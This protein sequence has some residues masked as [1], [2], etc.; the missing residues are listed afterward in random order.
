MH[1]HTTCTPPDEPYPGYNRL[2]TVEIF[3]DGAM[4]ATYFNGEVSTKILSEAEVTS[5]EVRMGA[6][7]GGA[8]VALDH[9][10]FNNLN[11]VRTA[12]RCTALHCTQLSS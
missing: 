1:G 11:T 9:V 7:A 8:I 2:P 12:L 10:A 6:G 3:V 5:M 4:V